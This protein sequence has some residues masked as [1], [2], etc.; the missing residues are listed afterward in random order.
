LL[1][2]NCSLLCGSNESLVAIIN[3]GYWE[4]AG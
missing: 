4:V 1:A 3:Y 2:G